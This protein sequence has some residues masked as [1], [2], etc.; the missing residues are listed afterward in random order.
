MEGDPYIATLG[1]GQ[2]PQ[3][4]KIGGGNALLLAGVELLLDLRPVPGVDV[5]QFC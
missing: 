1:S 2:L 4:V 3:S 5:S